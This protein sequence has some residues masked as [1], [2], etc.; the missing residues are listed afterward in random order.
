VLR[1][2]HL[3]GWR[4]ASSTVARAALRALYGGS[5]NFPSPL[6]LDLVSDLFQR[7]VSIKAPLLAA[8]QDADVSEDQRFCKT[9]GREFNPLNRYQAKSNT[10][11]R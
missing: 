9:E 11:V 3:F 5:L 6:R 10:Y 8:K 7:L 4:R 1:L 2:N